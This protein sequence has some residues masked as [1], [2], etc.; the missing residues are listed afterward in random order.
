MHASFNNG[1]W[2]AGHH[3]RSRREFLK[4]T[5]LG[6]GGVALASVPWIGKGSRTRPKSVFFIYLEGG[7]SQLDMYDMKPDAPAE[8][9]GEFRPINTNVPGMQVCEHLP[10]HAKVA[11]KFAIV[12]GVQTIDTHSSAV[13]TTGYTAD[14]PQRLGLIRWT[15]SKSKRRRF[16]W[17]IGIHMVACWGGNFQSLMSC[18]RNCRCTIN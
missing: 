6:L 8:I 1:F 7:P 3:G 4:A 17:A 15:R 10:L 16:H 12:N 2:Q 13:I 9:R 14:R 18:A 11:D 5:G